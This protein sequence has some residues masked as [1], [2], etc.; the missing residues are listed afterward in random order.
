MIGVIRVL[1]TENKGVLEEH[2]RLIA[3]QYG[4]RAVSRCIPDQPL[5]IYNEETERQAN[6]KIVELGVQLAEEGCRVLVISCAADPAIDLLR[7]SVDVPVVGAGSAAAH[8]A[9]ATGLPVG[10]MGITDDVP[11][12]V[13]KLLG[14]RFVAY[15]RPDGVTNT[16]QLLTEEG[17][18][19]AL[20]AA[21]SLLGQGT[22]L[23]LFA[24]TGFSTIGM[25]DVLRREL[26]VPVVDAVEAEGRIASSLLS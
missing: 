4:V 18:A 20:Q 12:N 11:A 19:L 6:P 5:G 1:T 16:T 3:E 9:L 13:K 21:R 8:L 22:K 25:A 24:C 2:G 23:I 26:G 10:V 15:A 14:S 17:R 7:E